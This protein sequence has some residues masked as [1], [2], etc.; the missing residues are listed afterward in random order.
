M[1]ED[2]NLVVPTQTFV[3]L[4]GS[5]EN[6]ASWFDVSNSALFVFVGRI[7]VMSHFQL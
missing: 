2:R 1:K 4:V 7:F 6:Y 3:D 5:V